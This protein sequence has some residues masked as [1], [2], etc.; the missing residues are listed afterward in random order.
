MRCE[1]GLTASG[2]RRCG[3]LWRERGL[4]GLIFSTQY[5]APKGLFLPF[6]R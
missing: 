5:Q 3:A 2:S 4:Y 6:K 1:R